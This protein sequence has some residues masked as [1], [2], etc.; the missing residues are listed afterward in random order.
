MKKKVLITGSSGFV[1]EHLIKY[2]LN[3][4]ESEIYGTYLGDSSINKL[5]EIKDK[6]NLEKIDLT[7]KNA[8]LELIKKIKPDEIYHLAAFTSP[9]LSFDNP[10]EV[11]S[12]NTAV[13]INILE[14]LKKQEMIAAKILIVSSGDVYGKV[15]EEDLPIDEDTPFNPSNPYA[16]SKLTQDFLGLQYFLAHRLSVARVRPFNHI[17]PGQSPNFVVSAFSKKIADIEK[18][19][20]E[21]VLK[22]GNLESRRDF[23]SVYDVVRAY[24][25]VLEKG[26][27][28][29]VYNIGSGK[30]Y[31]IG[32]ILEILL[33]FSKQKIK[34]EVDK[35]LFRPID[36][37][38]LICDYSKL[39]KLTGWEPEVSIEET[40]QETL[41]YW[42]NII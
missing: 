15:K 36:E 3:S 41:D 35:S 25:L 9:A 19:N 34:I 20:M 31:K 33:S 30:S 16:V 37:K 18:G 22:V 7:D 12:N 42:R 13:Q 32:D 28:G 10:Q 39:N 29:D 24:N 38:D 6:I 21:P 1:G 5:K 8:T 4:G 11:I 40:L 14:A 23:T 27:L 17:G 2:L 26:K